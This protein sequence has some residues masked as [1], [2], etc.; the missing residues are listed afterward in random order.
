LR[1]STISHGIPPSDNPAYERL[2]LADI[3]K[4]IDA[5]LKRFERDRSIN[6]IDPVSK[7]S[8]F[9]Y[10]GARASGSRVCITYITYQGISCI[11]KV[12]AICYLKW[13]DAGNVG[14]HWEARLA[15]ELVGYD[16]EVR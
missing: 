3:A 4:R 5:H 10:A 8:R 9:Y 13:L 12:E 1:Q 15:S 7:C 16:P 6:E 2:K 14:R 11:K